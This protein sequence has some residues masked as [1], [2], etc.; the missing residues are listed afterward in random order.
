MIYQSFAQLYDELFD[1]Q[2]YLQWRDYTLNR[3]A[4]TD[5]EILDL[6]GGAGRLAC[7]MAQSGLT[8]TVADFSSEMLS[9]ASKHAADAGVDLKLLEADMRDLSGFPVYDAVTC[10]ADSFCYLDNLA[11]VGQAFRQVYAHLASGGKFLFDVITPYQT[12]E[13]YPGYMYNYEDEDHARAFMWQSFADD[14][15]QHGVIHELTFFTRL[16]NGDYQRVS[17]THFER[18]YSLAELKTALTAAGFNQITVTANYGE[19]PVQPTTTRWFF[20]CQK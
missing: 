2:L 6:A 8:V 15:V 18:S 9:L 20:E 4:P 11:D 10:Y 7:L 16:P 1:G 17:E 14:D 5:K 13:V 19:K 12:D 3:L